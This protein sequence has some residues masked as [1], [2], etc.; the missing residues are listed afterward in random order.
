[1]KEGNVTKE[2]D[3]LD[4]EISTQ[5]DEG[6]TQCFL[7]AKSKIQEKNDKVKERIFIKRKS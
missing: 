7:V 3:D 5:S 6:A 1:M 4:K 2:V